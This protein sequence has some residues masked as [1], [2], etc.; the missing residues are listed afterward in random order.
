M[1]EQFSGMEVLW[2][3]FCH[4]EP[5]HQPRLCLSVSTGSTCKAQAGEDASLFI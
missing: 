3:N 1:A 4:K 5:L 2:I